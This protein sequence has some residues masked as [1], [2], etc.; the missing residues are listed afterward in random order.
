MNNIILI[1]KEQITDMM[2]F[3]HLQGEKELTDNERS[4]QT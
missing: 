2:T 3:T 1:T 4:K